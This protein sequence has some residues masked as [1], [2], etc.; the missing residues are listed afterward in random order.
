MGEGLTGYITKQKNRLIELE[1]KQA[2]LVSQ[3]NKEVLI[4]N[5]KDNEDGV[6]IGNFIVILGCILN[7]FK[8]IGSLS[9]G[10][11]AWKW[12]CVVAALISPTPL[13]IYGLFIFK[14]EKVR[15]IT[16]FSNWV[17]LSHKKYS[18][19]KINSYI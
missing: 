6:E 17:A 12:I 4:P 10:Y 8:Y 2:M 15:K 18:Y 16:N 3:N 9:V 11:I 19:P 13:L 7:L 5:R 1:S 14:E